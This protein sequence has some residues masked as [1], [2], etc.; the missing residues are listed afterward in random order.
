[1]AAASSSGNFLTTICGALYIPGP[2]S[3]QVHPGPRWPVQSRLESCDRK[4]S[5]PI[6]G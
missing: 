6:F 2:E 1:M 5:G 3:V 4:G